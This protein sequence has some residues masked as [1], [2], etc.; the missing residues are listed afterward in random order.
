MTNE[1]TQGSNFDFL[2]WF[3]FFN[4]NSKFFFFFK[5]FFF[6]RWVAQNFWGWTRSLELALSSIE[7]PLIVV[8]SKFRMH[9]L[10]HDKFEVSSWVEH[11]SEE[12][13]DGSKPEELYD[14]DRWRRIQTW[15]LCLRIMEIKYMISCNKF[16][17]SISWFLDQE[18]PF[19]LSI[20]FV[21]DL[22]FH[23]HSDEKVLCHPILQANYKR[24][25][26]HLP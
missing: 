3:Y 18:N 7:A 13:E 21:L 4:C 24:V 26:F 1:S 11:C 16:L 14:D 10:N 5:T 6:F 15:R 9:G 19:R 2:F 17:R 23:F 8:C 20:F 25:M 22:E 12:D